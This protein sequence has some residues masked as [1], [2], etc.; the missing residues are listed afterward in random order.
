M[1]NVEDI[2]PLSPMQEGILFHTRHDAAF[3]MYFEIITATLQGEVDLDAFARAWQAVVDRHP[4]LRTAFVWEGLDEPL[5]V[6]RRRAKLPVTRYDWR[7][8][9]ADQQAEELDQL[10]ADERARGFDLTKAPLMRVA[11]IQTGDDSYRFVWSYY[12]GLI[13]G[14]SSSLIFNDVFLFYE[15]FARGTEIRL[16]PTPSFRNYIEW[17]RAQDLGKAQEFWRRTLKSFNAATPIEFVGRK[18]ATIDDGTRSY[19][20]IHESL[21]AETTAKLVRLTRQH[22]LTLNTLCQGAWAIL[23]SRYSGEEDVLFG[24]A[25]SGRPPMLENVETMIGMLINTLPARFDVAPEAEF[26]PWLRRVQTQQTAMRDYEYSPLVQVQ[27]WSDAPRTEALFESLV[28]FENHLVDSSLLKRN[29]RAIVRDVRHHTTA[30]GYP[31]NILFEPGEQLT[32]KLL[33]DFARVE[34]DSAK[35]LLGHIATLLTEIAENPNRRLSEFSILTEPER[36]QLL[37]EFN[38]T[39][40]G[41]GEGKCLHHFFEEQAERTPDAI[42]VVFGDRRL[43][44]GELNQRANQLAHYLRAIDVGPSSLAGVMMD[45]SLDLIVALLGVLKTGAAYVPLDPAYPRERVRF[46]LED[47]GVTVLLTQQS[48]RD[49]LPPHDAH[50]VCLDTE[51]ERIAA[52]SSDSPRTRTDPSDL[53]YVIYTSGSTGR[54][55]GV[56]IEHQSA[57]TL[58][59]WAR[60]VFAVKVLKGVLASTSVCFDLSIFEIFVPLSTGGKVILAANAL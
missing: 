25:V 52:E 14:W 51:W 50:T 59:Q 39:A 40:A 6:V 13:D 26:I 24:V 46:M 7:S 57:A 36:R 18:S 15:A 33:Y 37:L 12:H 1:K 21:T 41:F 44:Y 49:D 10:F 3:A 28:S 32:V 43:T 55:K 58:I 35:R 30:T 22:Q 42:A 38:D 60:N 34:D 53:A 17:L 27:G 47:A 5:Q 56:A 11:L 2:Y 54:P 19:R 16:P 9:N 20:E 23:L 48:L 45:R 31:L 29:Q 4:V 8:L